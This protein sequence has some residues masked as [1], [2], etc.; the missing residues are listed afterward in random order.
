MPAAAAERKVAVFGFE[1]I[2]SSLEGSMLGKNEAQEA[3]LK[4]MAPML[5]KD[6]A[7]LDGYEIV[8]VA[9]VADKAAGANLQSCGNC[10]LTFAEEVGADVAV[11]GTVQKVS[12]LILNINAYA[13]DL[14]SGKEIA[15]GSADI[16]SNTDE[17]W[18]R[19]LT[20]L[21]ENRLKTQLEAAH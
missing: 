11:V 2:D 1:L 15:R 9:P 13:F 7:G 20:Y 16:R 17:S 14:S 8:D 12:N 10:A 5:R 19:G 3:R 21:F 18:D 6:I 4:R